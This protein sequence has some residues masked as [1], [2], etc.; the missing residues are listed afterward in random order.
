MAS[1]ILI[2]EK[3]PLLA[4]YLRGKLQA[5]G[6]ESF[7][8]EDEK[9]VWEEYQKLQPHLLLLDL[10]YVSVDT[11]CER[12]DRNG[13]AVPILLMGSL[14]EMEQRHEVLKR[15][16]ADG[17]FEK[18]FEFKALL[19][20]IR[21]LLGPLHGEKDSAA[22]APKEHGDLSHQDVAQVLA[23][24]HAIGGT[25]L[26]IFER[27]EVWKKIYLDSG[28]PVFALS[29]QIGDRLGSLLI[30]KGKLTPET[31]GDIWRQSQKE[32]K[33]L[34]EAL[35]ESGVVTAQEL[36]S[37]LKEQ[38]RNVILSVFSWEDGHY[39][40][41]LGEKWNKEPLQLD[42]TLVQ[43]IV[44]GV[45]YGMRLKCLVER[46]GSIRAPFAFSASHSIRLEELGLNPFEY[47]IACL[48]DGEKDLSEL[49]HW[50]RMEPMLVLK[51]LY[52]FRVLKL[53]EV[54]E[55][56]ASAS[57][58]TAGETFSVDL[59]SGSGIQLE[60]PPSPYAELE[61]R[62]GVGNYLEGDRE[63][64]I[65]SL[66]KAVELSPSDPHYHAYLALIVADLSPV[67]EEVF[68][69]A[70]G[71]LQK[72]IEL[73]ALDPR[74]PLFLGNVHRARG[75]SEEARRCY[76]KAVEIAPKLN[77]AHRLLKELSS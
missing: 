4:A 53:V 77:E 9:S 43:L 61:F 35:V 54:R 44:E 62:I 55:K 18:P 36:D 15:C 11:I 46:V 69:E 41:D 49:V 60:A 17:Y 30:R 22:P 27:G 20:H 2:A 23:S 16:R 33:L 26:L 71:H 56:E 76:Q 67:S 13:T 19:D 50:S 51:T 24:L 39:E 52:A 14:T 45:R 58:L 75:N 70:C 65:S 72:A 57:S 25:G 73:N 21:T 5:Q 10:S 38:M 8:I 48:I 31:L 59:Q 37:F 7:Y 6:Y 40:F 12:K 3:N 42:E 29:N 68:Q 66:K 64:A 1:K 47:A 63:G 28:S 34:G 74:Y 32:K